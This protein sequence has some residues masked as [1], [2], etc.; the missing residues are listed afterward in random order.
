MKT[1]IFFSVLL[2]IM[3]LAMSSCNT[4]TIEYRPAGDDLDYVIKTTKE[5]KKWGI[6][7]N[8][9]TPQFETQIV[10]C[11]YD[12]I[13]SLQDQIQFAYAG[14]RDGKNY[15]FDRLGRFLWEN[16]EFLAVSKISETDPLNSSYF[17]RCCLTKFTVSDG[18]L[19]VF[20]YGEDVEPNGMRVA[21]N[22][23]PLYFHCGPYENLFAG[24]NGYAYQKNGKW[25]IVKI[26]V[27]EKLHGI[28]LPKFTQLTEAQ[29]DGI[30]EVVEQSE[31]FW[32]VKREGKWSAIDKDG[33]QK[34]FSSQRIRTL[35]G[36]KATNW[37]KF[38]AIRSTSYQRVGGETVGCIRLPSR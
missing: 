20:Y 26:E 12:S 29:Y 1:K 34:R 21:V 28:F 10:P 31:S 15:A 33:K 5:S 30:I 7:K 27:G 25:G 18:N 9:A 36:K 6:V 23:S 24:T 16:G 4:E 3:A 38:N 37:N 11:I 17:Q 19:F 32:L 22:I 13:Y 2:G 35:L 14:I 8:H